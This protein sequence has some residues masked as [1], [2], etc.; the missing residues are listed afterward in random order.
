[1]PISPS[2]GDSVHAVTADAGSCVS[3]GIRILPWGPRLGLLA[4]LAGQ[5]GFVGGKVPQ[6]TQLDKN[7]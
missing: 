2:V 1:M 7:I 5:V 4:A 3:G 6:I